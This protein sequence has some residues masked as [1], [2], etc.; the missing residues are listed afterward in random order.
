MLTVNDFFEPES[1]IIASVMPEF[2]PRK[3]QADL[4]NLILDA[5][6]KRHPVIVEAPT[7]YGKSFAVLVP[8]IIKVLNSGGRVIISTETLAL[9]DQYY[10]KD[11]PMLQQACENKGIKFTYEV[12]KGRGNYICRHKL[13]EETALDTDSRLI[14]WAADQQPAFFE[15][16][17]WLYDTGDISSV[18]FEFDIKEWKQFVGA[19]EECGK[20]ACPFYGMG[21]KGSDCFAHEAAS[22]FQHAQIV[23]T[24]H[25]LLLLD[26]QI[27]LGTLLGEFDL[28][29]ID[30]GHSLAERAQNAW[31]IILKPTTVSR[32]MHYCNRMLKE[33][34]IEQFIKVNQ[35]K[36]LEQ[37]IFSPFFSVVEQST[38]MDQ[39]SD[40]VKG[41]SKDASAVIRDILKADFRRVDS[42]IN[43]PEGS[44]RTQALND[45]KEKISK[46]IHAVSAVY[47]DKVSEEVADNW[48]SF[49]ENT[50]TDK[51]KQPRII[52]NLKPVD[53][54]P[55]LKARIHDV[56]YCT[57]IMSATMRL[58]EGGFGFMKRELGMPETTVNFV[59]DTPFDFEKQ[60]VGYF[61]THL[62]DNNSRDYI[63][64]LTD[65]VV[66]LIDYW[67]GRT[68]ILFT[69]V[70]HMRQV[71]NA[72][73]NRVP[74]RCYI[75]GQMQKR[76][77]TEQFSKETQSC[78]FATRSFFT[79]VDIPGETLS[80]VAL[81]KAPFR[82]P[83]EPMFKAKCD[84]LDKHG[85]NSFVNYSMPLMLFDIRQSFG[86]LIRKT[87]DTG[88]FAL[89]DSKAMK[90]SYGASIRKAL[91][92]IQ[93]VRQLGS[94]PMAP[95]VEK[96]RVSTAL[97]ELD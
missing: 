51:S 26:A 28:L 96:K 94:A 56:I 32:T 20:R 59:G 91:P 84:L 71:Y 46:L 78:L 97:L 7:G 10:Y 21:K 61:P 34:G 80:C 48:L 38:K 50:Q 54:A 87:S 58:N 85:L 60:V 90:M 11:I 64:A 73:A 5:Y 66:K 93:E 79:G 39:I 67:K 45:I 69:N 76:V 2:I 12:A 49:V 30:E 89:L 25:T 40:E 86:R 43:E 75:Q 55:L 82:V 22:R 6:E 19:D 72:V 1:G 36:V 17:Q 62:P 70:S 9:Q 29:I 31:G 16:G 18:P 15:E 74:Y 37:D 24:N 68:M 42:R 77:L 53:V 35:Y 83:T 92:R 23:I 4:S 8:S 47:G 44:K 95:R 57:I 65:E 27:G 81:V 88:M 41:K 33:L 52:L 63:P 3:G 13:S 14:K